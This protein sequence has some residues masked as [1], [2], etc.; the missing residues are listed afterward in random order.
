MVVIVNRVYLFCLIAGIFLPCFAAVAER[1]CDEASALVRRGV[2]LADGSDEEAAFYR[3]AIKLCPNMAEAHHNLA[4][5]QYRA[6]QMEQ[7]KVSFTSAIESRDDPEFRI[8]LARLFLAQEDL[9]GAEDQYRA[10]LSRLESHPRATQGLAA[11]YDRQG[12][13]AE[14]GDLLKKALEANSRDAG[15]LY[16]LGL[17]ELRQGDSSQA[18]STF[19]RLLSVQP[20]HAGGALQ[21]AV[22]IGQKG[23]R[24]ESEEA[25]KLLR[26]LLDAN[27]AD[28]SALRALGLQQQRLGNPENSEI[29]LARALD[30]DPGDLRTK[31]NLALV[32]LELNKPALA[33]GVLEPV[34]GE[35]RDPDFMGVYGRIL[36]ELGRYEE[37]ERTLEDA[38]AQDA[39][40]IG[41]LRELHLLYTRWGAADKAQEFATRISQIEGS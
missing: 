32:R 19:R 23:Q 7:A 1:N 6:G 20:T 3:R 18:E 36:I 22:L 30:L 33:L 5:L 15:L 4:I 39:A 9:K 40:H 34:A 12:R 14:A 10:V 38:L 26:Q 24:D 16:A 21:L 17:I 31:I 37:A 35:I 2:L 29:S 11:I 25:V 8:G 13:T 28:I 41:V 27:P